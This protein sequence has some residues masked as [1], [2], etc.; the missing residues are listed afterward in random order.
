MWTFLCYVTRH[1]MFAHSSRSGN[2]SSASLEVPSEAL[3][4]IRTAKSP[5]QCG[6]FC[7]MV[8]VIATSRSGRTNYKSFHFFWDDSLQ[9]HG[10]KKQTLAMISVSLLRERENLRSSTQVR[11]TLYLATTKAGLN[12]SAVV[13]RWS[14]LMK[15]K[16]SLASKR[17]L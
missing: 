14:S 16:A 1:S 4:H 15:R 5:Q 17:F 10:A 3:L 7:A 11:D 12:G 8:G 6:L 9:Q 2:S 13:P